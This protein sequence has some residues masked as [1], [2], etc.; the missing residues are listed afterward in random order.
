MSGDKSQQ[1]CLIPREMQPG[2]ESVYV[3]RG[4]QTTV[5]RHPSNDIVLALDSISRFHSRIDKRGACR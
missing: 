5:G 1:A 3:L 2:M 4:D